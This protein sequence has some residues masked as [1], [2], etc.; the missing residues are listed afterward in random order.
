[1][2]NESRRYLTLKL[3]ATTFS[4]SASLAPISVDCRAHLYL[5][6][7]RRRF[8]S[9]PFSG[10]SCEGPLLN[11]LFF[12]PFRPP[13][14]FPFDC[15]IFVFICLVLYFFLLP[16]MSYPTSHCTL[17]TSWDH[18]ATVVDLQVYIGEWSYH[19]AGA[20]NVS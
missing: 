18:T 12:R 15:G 17:M 16:F 9:A 13:P 8:F 10:F 2:G 3:S 11:E 14:G 5:P 6:L 20:C 4:P 1:M 7:R 19:G